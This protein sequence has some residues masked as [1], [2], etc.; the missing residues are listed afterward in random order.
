MAST[1]EYLDNHL[2]KLGLERPNLEVLKSDV[3]EYNTLA[4]QHQGNVVAS[5]EKGLY[6][7]NEDRQ[8]A[9]KKFKDFFRLAIEE[10]VQL[11]LT[12]EYSCPW[13]NIENQLENNSLPEYGDLWIIGCESI[14][15]SELKELIDNYETD[16]IKFV[17]GVCRTKPI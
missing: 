6:V 5:R 2:E 15:P 16:T 17:L 8:I 12:P 14:L 1:F 3:N 13:D 4:Y 9:K 7:R 11:A 10:S